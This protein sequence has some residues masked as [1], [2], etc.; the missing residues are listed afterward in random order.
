MYICSLFVNKPKNIFYQLKKKIMKAV[1][2]LMMAFIACAVCMTSCE[3]PNNGNNDDNGGNGGGVAEGVFNVQFADQDW[4]AGWTQCGILSAQDGSQVLFVNAAPSQPSSQFPMLYFSVTAQ[5]GRHMPSTDPNLFMMFF[6]SKVFNL[7]D[8]NGNPI[9]SN[10]ADYWAGNGPQ[11]M[12]TA[13]IEI[14]A[15]DVATLTVTLTGEGKFWDALTYFQTNGATINE[16]PFKIEANNVKLTPKPSAN[17]SPI[18]QFA[19]QASET[20]AM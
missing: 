1:K 8:Q 12:G 9:M 17:I 3:K 4:D 19:A 20:V 18:A 13:S 7:Q 5:T 15:I 16:A 6:K 14:S 11:S 10:A 2:F